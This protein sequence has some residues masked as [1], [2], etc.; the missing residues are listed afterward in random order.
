MHTQPAISPGFPRALYGAGDYVRERDWRVDDE[1][2]REE[3]ARRVALLPDAQPEPA[4]FVHVPTVT[5]VRGGVPQVVRGPV[6]TTTRVTAETSIGWTKWKSDL[7]GHDIKQAAAS[8]ARAEQSRAVIAEGRRKRD[9]KLEDLYRG[10]CERLHRAGKAIPSFE[11]WKLERDNKSYRAAC[12]KAARAGLPEP[13][14]EQHF[15]PPPNY[16]LFASPALVSAIRAGRTRGYNA[17]RRERY[18]SKGIRDFAGRRTARFTEEFVDESGS[19]TVAFRSAICI[20]LAL[21]NSALP[22][23]IIYGTDKTKVSPASLDG[24]SKMDVRDKPYVELAR[25]RRCHFVVDLDG[26]WKSIKALWKDIRRFLPPQFMPNIITYRARESDGQGVENPHLIWLLPPGSRVIPRKGA[27]NIDRQ[28][29]LHAMIQRSI[30]NHLLELGVDPGH[31]NSNKLKNALAPGW[32]V[33]CCDDS[34]ATMSEWR[35]ILP[36]ITPDERA[37]MRRARQLKIEREND[38]EVELSNAVWRDGISSRTLVIRSAQRR[39]DP[40]FLKARRSHPAFVAWLYHPVDGAVTRRMIQLHGEGQVVR[41]VLAAQRQFVVELGHVPSVTG[42]FCDRG[43]DSY[44]NRLRDARSGLTRETAEEREMLGKEHQR[45]AGRVSRAD[46]KAINCGLIAEEIERR[47][48]LGLTIDE[49][50]AAKA[51][52]VKTL[53]AAGTVS[54]STAYDRFDEVAE[55]VR[56][57]ARYQAGSSSEQSSDL[58]STQPSRAV[59]DQSAPAAPIVETSGTQS[60]LPPAV[61]RPVQPVDPS[62]PA[63]QHA[64]R[65]LESWRRA[66]RAWRDAARRRDEPAESCLPSATVSPAYWSKRRH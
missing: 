21:F 3:F 31:H 23:D 64:R 25:N 29:T 32:S 24:T 55:V 52:V 51:E 58:P 36:T 61:R 39:R 59:S 45:E 19:P 41:Q 63:G 8:R 46:A 12:A 4:P 33:A 18:D 60:T 6:R 20:S 1:A 47:M 35:A 9:A 2:R 17:R 14:R 30:V 50:I 49:V 40:D 66:V 53:V 28:Q 34:F 57:A 56:Q 22:P 42:Q 10:A 27:K 5:I 13:T 43:R 48:A 62:E 7:R 38:A 37:M 11:T 54:R 15:A 44:R 65:I 26:W 16:E